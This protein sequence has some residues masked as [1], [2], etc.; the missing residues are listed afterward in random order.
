MRPDDD[1]I[2][3]E[4]ERVGGLT[5]LARVHT[6]RGYRLRPDDEIV[7]VTLRSSIAERVI[8]AVGLSPSRMTSGTELTQSPRMTFKPL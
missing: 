1:E 8:R 5:E 4:L 2:L 7:E 6:F 3:G